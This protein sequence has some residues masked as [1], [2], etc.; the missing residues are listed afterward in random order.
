MIW[1]VHAVGAL[2]MAKHHIPLLLELWEVAE[3]VHLEDYA[4]PHSDS[5][6][7]YCKVLRGTGECDCRAEQDNAPLRKLYKALQ[8]LKEHKL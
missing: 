8:A 2:V 1:K 5:D 4:V 7:H 3:A 6:A